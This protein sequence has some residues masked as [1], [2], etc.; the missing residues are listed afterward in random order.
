MTLVSITT[1][2]IKKNLKNY[3]SYF[4][5]LSFSIFSVYLFMSILYSKYIQDELGE[6]KKFI[7]LFNV[8]AVIIVM[9]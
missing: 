6:M 2:N 9:F 3:W 1:R 8:G 7:T 4:L 5:S